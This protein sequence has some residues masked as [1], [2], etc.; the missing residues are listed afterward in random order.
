[1]QAPETPVNIKKIQLSPKLLSTTAKTLAQ[2]NEKKIGM[3]MHSP[4]KLIQK[5]LN[6]MGQTGKVKDEIQALKQAN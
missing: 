2:T 4:L 3:K 6:N 1:M 5:S